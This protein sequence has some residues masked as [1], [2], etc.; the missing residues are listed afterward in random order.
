MALPKVCCFYDVLPT[1]CV[2]L[3]VVSKETHTSGVFEAHVP[4]MDIREGQLAGNRVRMMTFRTKANTEVKRVCA[5]A[6]SKK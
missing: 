1:S 6:V 4:G 5:P 3:D 2:T